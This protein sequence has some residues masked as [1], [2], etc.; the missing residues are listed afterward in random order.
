MRTVRRITYLSAS[1]AIVVG[2]A[3]AG[4]GAA[5]AA[6]IS[7]PTVEDNRVSVRIENPIPG[8][9]GWPPVLGQSCAGALVPLYAIPDVARDVIPLLDG[10]ITNIIA[11]LGDLN[12]QVTILLLANTLSPVTLPGVAGTLEAE[13]VRDDF[14]AAPVVCV[15]GRDDAPME[16][17]LFLTQVGNPLGAFEGS[18]T[19]SVGGP[20]SA[21]GSSIG[22]GS[23]ELGVGSADGIIELVSASGSDQ[24]STVD[25][26]F[27]GSIADVTSGSVGVDA[28]TGSSGSE[29]AVEAGR[30]SVDIASTGALDTSSLT[31]SVELPEGSSNGS[32]I[33]VGSIIPLA[34]DISD[35]VKAMSFPGS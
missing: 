31:G 14:Y 11:A 15:G 4:S 20:G 17:N 8:K 34:G 26:G 12:D 18:V 30:G 2:M 32:S 35:S 21:E 16:I 22:L 9:L 13:H 19:G 33:D 29:A 10:D 27:H 6:D 25:I 28:G 1:V 23:A 3:L 5:L 24:G 7:L